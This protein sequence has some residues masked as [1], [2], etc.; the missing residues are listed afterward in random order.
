MTSHDPETERLKRIRDRQL[1]LR[2]PHKKGRKLQR[3]ITKRRS[4]AVEPFSLGKMWSEI[5]HRWK[6]MLY[7]AALGAIVIVGLPYVWDETWATM[8][9]VVAMVFLI[10]VG[11]F[12]GRAMDAR[13][14]LR[15][16]IH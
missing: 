1:A 16:L 4:K 5:P 11:F 3:T 8:A 2:D 9:G 6:G 14:S 13:N 15:D 10:V 7:G 12:I